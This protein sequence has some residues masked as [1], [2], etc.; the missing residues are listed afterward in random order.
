MILGGITLAF[1]LMLLII[2]IEN[3]RDYYKTRKMTSEE[4][5]DYYIKKYL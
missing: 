3:I 5:D 1:I 2:S 4:K